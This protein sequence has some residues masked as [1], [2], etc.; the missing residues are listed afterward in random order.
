MVYKKSKEEDGESSVWN[1]ARNYVSSKIHKWLVLI[2]NY[3]TLAI[4]G[5]NDIYGDIFM[6]DNNLK[7]TA[8]LNALKRLIHSIKTLIRNTKFATK[9]DD[10][11]TFITHTK[12]LDKILKVVPQLRLE[13]KRGQR[14]VKIDIN[15]E[16][17]EKIIDEIHGI[18]DNVNV[19]INKAGLIFTQ[20]EDFDLKKLKENLEKEFTE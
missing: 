2:D 10:K 19:K 8:R 7:N 11:E 12:R 9:K 5:T 1:D 6:K 4:F 14:V 3:E 18:I 17:F 13:T 15:E 20:L 16:L